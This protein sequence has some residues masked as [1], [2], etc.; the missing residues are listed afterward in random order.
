MFRQP[1][2]LIARIMQVVGL[3]IV[4]SL[5]FAPLKHDYFA[6]QNRLGFLIEIGPLYFVGS[7]FII[8]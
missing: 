7:K 4:L 1:E 2:I 8:Y 6:V 5:Y 3:G